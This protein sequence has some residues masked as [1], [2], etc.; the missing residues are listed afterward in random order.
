M[1]DIYIQIVQESIMPFLMEIPAQRLQF[2]EECGV[3][4][5]LNMGIFNPYKTYFDDTVHL[6]DKHPSEHA[7]NTHMAS[8]SLPTHELSKILQELHSTLHKKE[9]CLFLAFSPH[10]S[11]KQDCIILKTIQTIFSDCNIHILYMELPPEQEVQAHWIN[12]CKV[13]LAVTFWEYMANFNKKNNAYNNS[14]YTQFLSDILKFDV[15]KIAIAQPQDIFKQWQKWL[16]LPDFDIN[17]LYFSP[18][19][20]AFIRTIQ[21]INHIPFERWLLEKKFLTYSTNQT[22]NCNILNNSIEKN[23]LVKYTAPSFLPPYWQKKLRNHY[24]TISKNP[25]PIPYQEPLND[26]SN[27]EITL[28]KEDAKN[29]ASLL[30]QSLRI[31]LLSNVTKETIRHEH[32]HVRYVYAALLLAENHI[33]LQEFDNLT[34]IPLGTLLPPILSNKNEECQPKNNTFTQKMLTPKVAVLTLAYNH[35]E[36]IEDAIK[37]VLQQKTNFPV[38]HIIKDD[39]STDNTREILLQYAEKYPHIHLILPNQKDERTHIADFFNEAQTPYV[40]LCDG[41]DYFYDMH[42]LQ[43]QADLLDNNP[44]FALCFHP[45]HIHNMHNPK[46]NRTHPRENQ[47][48]RGIKPFYYLL[49]LV[50]ENIIQTNSVMY[51][52]RFQNGLPAWFNPNLLPSDWYWHLLHAENGKIG[53]QNEVMSVYRRHDKS[54]FYQ[55][56]TNTA[57][58]RKTFGKSEIHLYEHLNLHFAER[59]KTEFQES[60]FKVL[61]DLL[62]H[63]QKYSDDTAFLDCL[64]TFPYLALALQKYLQEISSSIP[65]K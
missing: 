28:N 51:R 43:K 15:Q 26:L 44:D 52:W 16:K 57:Q 9:H 65:K 4:F 40:A 61:L 45:V 50:R 17:T 19:T 11:I 13:S 56:E 7:A 21:T 32:K 63:A 31:L 48:Y 5:P 42:K 49:D 27:T 35:Q 3:W 22:E 54:L 41:D 36:Y 46:L 38:I 62:H 59:Y 60:Q 53:F 23:N 25:F 39:C 64:D 14:K 8:G 37:S 6:S 1:K 24:D 12:N 30:T 34:Q 10:S 29:L 58:H 20:I 47:L 18:M 2:L 55:T 33:N